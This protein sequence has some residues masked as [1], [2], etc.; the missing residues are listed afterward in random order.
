M[1]RLAKCFGEIIVMLV[2]LQA[3]LFF[4]KGGI[5]K[6]VSSLWLNGSNDPLI[7]KMITMTVMLV[8][9]IVV[10]LYAHVRKTDLSVFPACFSKKY[11]I[12][13]VLAFLFLAATPS[14]YID[15]GKGFLILLYGSIVT[16]V[17]E[18]LLFRGL[19]WN[20]LKTVWSNEN[21]VLLAN[22]I[23]FSVW[24]LGYIIPALIAGEWLALSK[25]AIGLVYG[26]ILCL[27]RKKTGNC[28]STM[29]VH[30]VLNAFLG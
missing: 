11:I 22:A 1:K 10:C 26:L 16:P 24:H 7:E 8:L 27:I 5:L 3:C 12:F 2:V 25:L 17:Y 19:I 30:G 29:L 13:S 18:E 4:Y 20:L 9:T 15:G 23:L 14:N 28:Y 21:K 6:A